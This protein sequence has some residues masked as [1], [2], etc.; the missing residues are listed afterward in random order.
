MSRTETCPNLPIHP[1]VID[2]TLKLACDGDEDGFLAMTQRLE[3]LEPAINE[4][5]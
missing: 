4:A 2:A 3:A 1:S 5:A